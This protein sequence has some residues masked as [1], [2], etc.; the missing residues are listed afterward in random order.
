MSAPNSNSPEAAVERVPGTFP[1]L[2]ATPVVRAW[3]I[4][5]LLA[6]PAALVA[7]VFPRRMGPHLAASGWTAA[8]VVHLVSLILVL[9]VQFA[10]L[11]EKTD[12]PP[13]HGLPSYER[14]FAEQVRRPLAGFALL[15]HTGSAV[16]TM[17]EIGLGILGTQVAVWLVAVALMPMLAAGESRGRLYVRCVKLLL[18]SSACTLVLAFLLGPATRLALRLEA[19]FLVPAIRGL[20]LLLGAAW[21]LSVLL[22]LGSR[23]GG[24]AVGPG[25]TP[26]V[27]RCEKCAYELTSLPVTG[28]CPE[29]G[30]PVAE[31]LPERREPPAFAKARGVVAATVAYVRTAWQ[32]L[33]AVRFGRAACVWRGQQAARRF[34]LVTAALVGFLVAAGCSPW[35]VGD[36]DPFGSP[37]MQATYAWYELAPPPMNWQCLRWEMVLVTIGLAAGLCFLG[38][39]LAVGLVVTGF[40]FREATR[41]GVVL[42]YSAAGLAL[43]VVLGMLAAWGIDWVQGLTGMGREVNLPLLGPVERGMIVA[44][45]MCVPAVAALLLWLVQLRRMLVE[46]R[47]AN[48]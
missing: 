27:L 37:V 3:R 24:P 10:D 9:G 32:T 13:P 40:G 7:L 4:P 46:T 21:W 35:V 48:A 34:A 1:A 36:D 45:A 26:R 16:W 31:S 15:F 47:Y 41:R 14:T 25:W 42:C 30:R 5:W 17:T 20:A 12:S 11:W 43:A 44:V 29:C 23:H 6:P 33:F 38:G 2:P 39:L 8:Y 22:Q 19:M 18:W 28:R